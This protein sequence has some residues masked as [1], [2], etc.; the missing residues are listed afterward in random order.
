MKAPL[1]S[2][3]LGH[4]ACY[5]HPVE[6]LRRFETHISVVHLTGRYAYKLK[7]PIALGFL[8]FTTLESRRQ[9]CEDEVRLN[10]RFA[11]MLYL[12][13]VPVTVDHEGAHVNGPGTIVDYAVRMREFPQESL[14]HHELERGTLTADDVTQLAHRIARFQ[15][16][17][18]AAPGV[19]ATPDAVLRYAEENLDALAASGD[20]RMAPLRHWTVHTHRAV[21]ALLA[22]RHADGHVR[23]GHGDLHLANVVR[24]DGALMPFDGIE[25]SAALRWND[26]IGDIA[27]LV[28]DLE[29]R[30]APE[31]SAVFLDAWL[32]ATGDYAALPLLPFFI[33]YRALVRAK[34]LALRVH[35]LAADDAERQQLEADCRRYVDLAW[36]HAH[37]PRGAL[38]LMHGLSG[39]GK[40]VVA[41]ELVSRCRGIR[42]RA[43]VERKR[44][45]GLA[46][47][48]RT[49]ADYATGLYSEASTS[50]TYARLLAAAGAVVAGGRIAIVDATFLE[51]AQRAPFVTLA[52]TSGVP[53]AV[54]A[55]EAP[56]EVL[57]A[58]IRER[59][60][61][62]ADP[63][64]ATLAVLAAQQAKREPLTGDALAHT[65]V[66]DGRIGVT[67]AA[68]VALSQ[69]GVPVPDRGS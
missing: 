66:V 1:V 35:E 21:A 47:L 46:A 28:M 30:G 13:V 42:I 19:H 49:A 32:A 6:R 61:T 14:A 53:W 11:P 44:L 33:V 43:D 34:V 5:P 67:H 7:K 56:A 9:A 27:F 37:A 16:S 40:S 68:L 24:I 62:G 41:A 38:L 22:A 10:R 26:V 18:A 64:D 65:V 39:S 12:D 58:R 4:P 50:A 45:A 31:L 57:Q 59:A 2:P 69:L 52:R 29:D 25:F 36:R 54:I 23:E 20:A 17:A 63:S 60:A 51:A 3:D 48:A 8:D 15:E 55:V